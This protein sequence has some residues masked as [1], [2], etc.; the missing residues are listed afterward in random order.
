MMG[1]VAICA[2]VG[3]DASI[4][5]GIIRSGEIRCQISDAV[6]ISTG[7]AASDFAAVLLTEEAVGLLSTQATYDALAAQPPWSDLPFVVLTSQGASLSRRA[8]MLRRLGNVVQVARPVHPG[9]LIELV[10]NALR[11]RGRQFVARRY[12]EQIEDAELKLEE[13]AAGLERQITYRTRA[14]TAAN[15]R[16]ATQGR[17]RIQA[18]EQLNQLQ[19]ELI[20]VS[21]GSAMDTMASTLAHELNQPLTAVTNYL[22]GSIRM[23]QADPVDGAVLDGL[24]QALASAHRA[25]EIVRRIRDLVSR[26]LVNRK[27]EDLSKLIDEAIAVG[28]IDGAVLGVSHRLLP[29]R[30]VGSVLVDRVQIQQVLINL[31]RNAVEA[32]Q[33]AETREIVIATRKLNDSLVEVSVADTGHGLSPEILAT[34]FSSFRTT[35]QDGMGV[36]LSICRTIVEANGGAISGENRTE[37]GAVFR[38]TLPV[39]APRA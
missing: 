5:E 16:L 39:G 2:P 23:L 30:E 9:A 33:G 7:I 1:P 25:G 37:G 3:R 34:L 31:L 27:P 32:M 4:I 12:L 36:G 24:G 17:Q 26:G 8:A 6:E 22:H 11:A 19:S 18:Q 14:L 15:R 38:F 10:R 35:K 20:H 21:R 28:L 13:F 29:D